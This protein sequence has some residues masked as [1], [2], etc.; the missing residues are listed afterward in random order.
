MNGE[1]V[2]NY[3]VSYAMILAIICR[4]SVAIWIWDAVLR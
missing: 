1:Q 4:L 2:T 3:C